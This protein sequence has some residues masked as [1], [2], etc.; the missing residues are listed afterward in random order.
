LRETLPAADFAVFRL[1]GA[2]R[3]K[4]EAPPVPPRFL[5]MQYYAL[6]PKS[7]EEANASASLMAQMTESLP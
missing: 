4:W 3:P 7:E 6:T 1:W 5:F 2:A